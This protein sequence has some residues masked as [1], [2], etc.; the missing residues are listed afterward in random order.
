M[1][2]GRAGK[3]MFRNYMIVLLALLLPT[4]GAACCVVEDDCGVASGTAAASAADNCCAAD[5][6]G[7]APAQRSAAV[8]SVECPATSGL[9]HKNSAPA[10]P[11]TISGR[12]SGQPPG[13]LAP[14]HVLRI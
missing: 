3:A 9:T 1:Y 12:D 10:L 11:A 6:C 2:H 8:N 7:P 5:E 14:I 4:L 13:G